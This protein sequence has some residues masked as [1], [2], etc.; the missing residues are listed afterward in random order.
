MCQPALQSRPVRSGN[1]SPRSCAARIPQTAFAF[2][3]VGQDESPEKCVP[4]PWPK[5]SPPVKD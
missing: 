4:E 2:R 5:P 1:C 3:D